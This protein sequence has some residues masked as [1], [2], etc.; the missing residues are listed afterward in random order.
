M[1][2]YVTLTGRAT[3]DLEEAYQWYA[4]R[5][6][7]TAVGWYNG[8]L[9]ALSSLERNPERCPVAPEARKLS[10][11]IRQLLFGRRRSYRALF[12]VRKKAVVVLHIRHAA[13]REANLEDIL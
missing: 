6:P 10:V 9:D 11:E 2:Y 1:T 5:A 12:V 13:R 4:D 8:F 3:K 7:E